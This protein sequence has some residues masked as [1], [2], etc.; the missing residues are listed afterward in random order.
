MVLEVMRGTE[1][2][3]REAFTTAIAGPASREDELS[4][5]RGLRRR[6]WR[7][8]RRLAGLVHSKTE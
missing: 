4:L 7:Y 5:T 1:H 8:L 3:L 2:T 6:L